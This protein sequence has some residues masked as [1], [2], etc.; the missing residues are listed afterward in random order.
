MIIPKNLLQAFS[1]GDLK[2][3]SKFEGLIFDGFVPFNPLDLWCAVIN[4]RVGGHGI[5]LEHFTSGI[6]E[7]FDQGNLNRNL[8]LKVSPDV[9]EAYKT[10][11]L[12]SKHSMFQKLS[13]EGAAEATI[14]VSKL[15]KFV[16]AINQGSISDPD[17]DTGWF[18]ES[19]KKVIFR[20]YEIGAIELKTVAMTSLAQIKAF[21]MRYS[22]LSIHLD[23]T[24]SE[25]TRLCDSYSSSDSTQHQYIADLYGAMENVLTSLMA[26]PLSLKYDVHLT[27]L[28]TFTRSTAQIQELTQIAPD[29]ISLISDRVHVTLSQVCKMA[30]LPI[31]LRVVDALKTRTPAR[32]MLPGVALVHIGVLR[33][34]ASGSSPAR[35]VHS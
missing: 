30:D 21:E 5:N 17:L 27:K 15:T 34:Q 4:L 32:D 20:L 3:V 12:L 22:E 10:L 6:S 14:Q 33:P 31:K 9:I 2:V 16:Q 24:R 18:L 28:I 35:R 11:D 1:Q 7:S 8:L 26:E 19:S 13:P 29:Y 23:E 25:C